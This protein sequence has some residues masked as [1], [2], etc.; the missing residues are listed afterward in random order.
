MTNTKTLVHN[1]DIIKGRR[2]AAVIGV[3][4]FI[5]ATILGAYVRIPVPGSPIPITLQTFFVLLSGAVLGKRLGFLSM[6][7]YFVFG[8]VTLLGP[9]FGYLIGFAAASYLIGAMLDRRHSAIAAFIAGDITLLLCGAFWL[10][11]VYNVSP[12]SAL[13]LGVLPFITGDV[14][15]LSVAAIIYSKISKRTNEIFNSRL[16]S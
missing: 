1:N 11:C 5:M 2:A 6:A 4:F 7:G 15:K 12:V 9:T 3:T 13:S 16:T 10:I 8:G 14:V